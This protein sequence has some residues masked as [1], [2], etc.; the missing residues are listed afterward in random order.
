MTTVDTTK[1]T[2]GDQ[3]D[4]PRPATALA[5]LTA[6]RDPKPP[7]VDTA[8]P[9]RPEWLRTWDAFRVASGLSI[10][11]GAYRTARFLRDL[12]ALVGLLVLYSP[13]G[14]GRVVAALS[15]YLYDYDSAAVRHAHAANTETAEYV[16][17]Q[18]VRKAN[19]RARWMVAGTAGLI[20]VG[21][22]L[23]WTAPA[24]LAVLVA[25]AVFIWTTKLI[26]GRSVWEL[27]GAA[28]LAVAVWWSLPGLL[29][30][31]PVP[32]AWS[33]VL[34]LVALVLALGWVGRPAGKQMVKS[35]DFAKAGIVE[36]PTAE[37]VIDALCRINVPGM[38]LAATDRVK[39]EIRVRAPGVARSVR[40]Y[41]IE[42]E[43]PG[44]ITAASVMDRR[45]N[46]AGALRRKLGTVWPSRGTD[47]PGHLRLFLADVP[48]ATAPQSRWPLAKGQP[49]DIF[50]PFPLVTDEEGEWVD[51]AL[52]GT[53]A[54][55]GG[56]SGFGKSVGLRQLAV[57]VAFDPRV[58]LYV[59]DGKI[60]GD[61]DPVRKVA[62]GYFEGVEDDDIQ[63][64]LAALRGI[65]QEMRRR[66]RF[67]RD[68]PPE[69]RSPKVTS[70]LA[71]KYRGLSPIVVLLDECQEYTEYGTKG[72][73]AEMKVR[74][75][76]LRILTR[77]SRLGRSAGVIVVYVSQKPDA[78]VL[79]SAIM[80]NCSVRLCFKV[81]EQVHNDQILGTGAYKSGLKATLFSQEDRGLAWLKASGDPRVVR[82]WSEMVDLDPAYE[83]V[84]IAYRLRVERDLLTGQAAGEHEVVEP[85][86]DL[87]DDVHEVLKENACRNTSLDQLREALALLSPGI[88]GH[89][90]NE[91]LGGLLRGAGVRP[92]SIHCPREG[93]TMRGVKVD[94]VTDAI[95]QRDG[96]DLTDDDENLTAG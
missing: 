17:A 35:A 2:E 56:A 31:L 39:D 86:A 93:R 90:D 7:A 88:Y 62:H 65:E 85:T 57:A 72:D 10:R 84:E 69:E 19:L 16:K 64:Q 18:N 37:M 60:S 79:P 36:K 33:V 71:S 87:L 1:T 53:H 34:A 4:E 52:A 74:G 28:G 42:L 25:V 75:E 6:G 89:L 80:G 77:L 13:R 22:V 83:L 61:L 14:L 95:D 23:A 21:P 43:L 70:A 11:R 38:T 12:P 66:S 58:R 68:L 51:V 40:G 48:M 24:V 76:F 81:T 67:L 55:I 94:W 92:D 73:K 20:V 26:P 27:V 29:A 46:L 5:K 47:H 8:E 96:G 9:I 3:P 49:I 78:E 50:E 63:E 54:A 91:S 59:F 15:R 32:P 44:G 30:R 41:L 45:E 82:T